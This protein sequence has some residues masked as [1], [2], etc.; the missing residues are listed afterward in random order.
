MNPAFP[1]YLSFKND[2]ALSVIF[3]YETANENIQ[4]DIYNEALY[5]ISLDKTFN[6][7]LKVGIVSALP[8][9]ENFIYQGVRD[10]FSGFFKFIYREFE[11]AHNSFDVSC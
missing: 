5:F 1:L 3:Q 4:D 9:A 8:F 2:F 7:N 11:I 10:S 6:N